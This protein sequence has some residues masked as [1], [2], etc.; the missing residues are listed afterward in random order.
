MIQSLEQHPQPPAL[1]QTAA[2]KNAD[3]ISPILE[4][5]TS[6]K[7]Q[8]AMVE[9]APG[10]GKSYT[11]VAV[12]NELQK[13]CT[14]TPKAVVA[15][16]KQLE[17]EISPKLP[18]GVG[19]S[20][21]HAFGLKALKK[22]NQNI[23]MRGDKVARL[24]QR[25]W[26]A[27]HGYRAPSNAAPELLEALGQGLNLSWLTLT[28]DAE[29]IAR[30]QGE[31]VEEN[32]DCIEWALPWMRDEAEK[33]FHSRGDLSFAEMIYYPAT[34]NIK[35]EKYQF[36]GVDECQDLSAAALEMILKLGDHYLMVGDPKQAIYEFAGADNA[37]FERVKERINPVMLELPICRRSSKA[38]IATACQ[39][40]DAIQPMDTALEGE[41]R[42][43]AK[44]EEMVGG[45]MVLARHNQQLWE[46]AFTLLGRGQAARIEGENMSLATRLIETFDEITKKNFSFED[47]VSSF[48]EHYQK[49]RSEEIKNQLLILQSTIDH[50]ASSKEEIQMM[51]TEVIKGS[52]S[53]Q[54]VT[55]C[56]YHRSKGL[57]ADSVYVLFPAEEKEDGQEKNLRFVSATRAKEKM[58]FVASEPEVQ[59]WLKAG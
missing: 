22:H 2:R 35:I 54:P 27:F 24:A 49:N 40:Y 26:N 32:R 5:F 14:N 13:R 45:D 17:R 46:C 4:N 7:I 1:V 34:K 21:L 44:T 25:A 51:V 30:V 38:V 53:E 42:Y 37:S 36:I 10:S 8:N 28:S 59:R 52:D 41:V 33:Q 55:L 3:I 48:H 57:E 19:C 29:V 20:T 58:A 6:S 12:F 56:S 16:S 43:C 9:A 18:R 50:G 39:I 23:Q 31:V 47:S 15:F 11:L